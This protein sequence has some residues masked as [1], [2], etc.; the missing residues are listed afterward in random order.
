MERQRRDNGATK[1][2]QRSDNGATKERQKRQQ[3]DDEPGGLAT[4]KKF[5]FLVFRLV[6]GTMLCLC[7]EFLFCLILFTSCFFRSLHEIL[8][9]LQSRDIYFGT[10]CTLICVCTPYVQESKKLGVLIIN[11]DER[12]ALARKNGNENPIWNWNDLLGKHNNQ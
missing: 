7:L 10:N 8:S 2:R 12:K 5:I 4:T 11:K 3:L 1:E 9:V 6:T